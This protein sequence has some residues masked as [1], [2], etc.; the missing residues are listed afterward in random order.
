M[1]KTNTGTTP[2][3]QAPP[4]QPEQQY[5]WTTSYLLQD[6]KGDLRENSNGI[7]K[8]HQRIESLRADMDQRFQRVFTALGIGFA[9]VSTPIVVFRFVGG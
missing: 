4:R 8:L 1:A 2:K 9:V 3:Q 5:P 7:D 6:M